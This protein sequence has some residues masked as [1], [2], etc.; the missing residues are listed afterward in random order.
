MSEQKR[1]MDF[2]AAIFNAIINVVIDHRKR[3]ELNNEI[4]RIVKEWGAAG[5]LT[6]GEQTY[7]SGRD[8]ILR[9]KSR[10]RSVS[11]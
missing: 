4:I 8:A 11:D 10:S 3:Q 7:N 9:G 6:V 2:E 1:G 5:Q